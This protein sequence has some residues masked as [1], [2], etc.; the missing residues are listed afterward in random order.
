[1]ATTVAEMVWLQRMFKE[2]GIEIRMSV[3]L[4]YDS[5]ATIQI[6][7]HPIFRER[8]KHFDMACHFVREKILMGLIQ[9]QHIRTKY[10]EA[11]LLTKGLC[12]PQHE[13]LVGKLRMK[14]IFSNSQLVGEC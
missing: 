13:A 14:N 4:F 3:K 8:T 10:Q 12:K 11:N 5:K 7:D 6:A 9:T 2:L 1:M